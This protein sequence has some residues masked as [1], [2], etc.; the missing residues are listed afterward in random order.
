[1]KIAISATGR[2]V[3]SNIDVRFG[4]ASFFLILDTKTKGVK[5]I[6]N[7]ARERSS[8]VGITAV[9]V[10]ANEGIDA[11][12][13]TDIGPPS[14]EILERD[15]IKM[16]QA[17]GKISDAIQQFTEGKLPEITK[18]TVQKYMGSNRKK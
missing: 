7:K 16:Y 10:V 11:V 4:R 9:N 12:I 13:T 14:F 6:V 15:G 2:D 3:E 8:G 5:A 18:P 17:K 1:M